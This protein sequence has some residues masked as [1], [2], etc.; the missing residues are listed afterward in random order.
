MCFFYGQAAVSRGPLAY[1][2][3]SI[4]NPGVDIFNV[5]LDLSTLQPSQD[6]TPPGG[7]TKL[8]GQAT[9]IYLY[10][11]TGYLAWDNRGESQMTVFARA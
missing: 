9:A 1:C 5:A 3:E 8:I 7:M 4:D 6:E 11:L 10:S 2:L